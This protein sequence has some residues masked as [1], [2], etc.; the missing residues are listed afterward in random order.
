ML[1]ATTLE[2][3]LQFLSLLR[4]SVA[5]QRH[6][7]MLIETKPWSLTHHIHNGLSWTWLCCRG[8]EFHYRCLYLLRHSLPAEMLLYRSRTKPH[9]NYLLIES[10]SEPTLILLHWR[11]WLA[12]GLVGCYA[13]RWWWNRGGD[14]VESESNYLRAVAVILLPLL[15]HCRME[16]DLT[17]L[18]GLYDRESSN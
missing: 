12:V 16:T 18:S 2:D 15:M 1:I 6:F 17:R 9:W 7:K 11:L 10:R 5:K 8:D 4:W 3:T 14:S 13:L